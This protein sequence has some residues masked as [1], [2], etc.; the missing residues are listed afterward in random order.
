MMNKMTKCKGDGCSKSAVFDI[1]GG[2]GRYCKTHK[3]VDMVNV[4]SKRCEHEGC[5]SLSTVFDVKGGKG[6]FC[7]THKTANMVSVKGKRCEQEGCDSLSPVYDVKGGKG[8]FCVAHKTADMIDVIHKRCEQEECEKQPCFDIAG[9]KGRFC[10]IHKLADMVNIKSKRCEHEGCDS[11]T[12]SFALEGEKG[13]F[14]AAHKTAEMINVKA[15]RCEHEGCDKQ[16]AFD[17]KGGKP[18]FCA[19]HKAADMVNLVSKRCE[20]A[21]CDKHPNFAAKDGV[22]R[23]CATHR[24]ADMTDV[25]SNRCIH[26]GCDVLKPAF[27]VKGEHGRYCALHKTAD[28]VNVLS[29]RCEHDGCESINRSFD[30]KGGKG[31]FCTIHKTADMV[32]VKVKRCEHEGCDT[33]V[34]YGKPGSKR[35]HCSKHREAGMIR[36]PNAKCVNCKELAIWG[37]HWTPVHCD[38]H[39]TEDDE[40]LAERPCISCGLLYVLDKTNRCELCHPESWATAR[41]VKQTALMDYLD[42]RDLKGAS[43]DTLVDGGVCGKE[44]PDRV[45]DFG[46][47]IVILECDEH[48]HQERACLCEQNRMVN[49]GQTFGGVP[50][51]FIRW[52]PDNYSPKSDRKNPELL[53]KRHKLCGDLIADI[54][55]GKALLPVALVSAIYLYYDDWSSLA[56]ESWSILTK[57]E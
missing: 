26:E 53:A 10:A 36:N 1:K 19:T 21:G 9:G 28:M 33:S 20:H 52:N 29:K 27:N 44:R 3:L 48:Q 41:L 6:R 57:Y 12:P 45:Y 23:F 16:P 4:K 17:V 47:K 14:C 5:E 39:K 51:Y 50:V 43:T 11:I 34:R 25:K 49:I 24:T 35:S 13:R 40:N 18:R 7:S 46:D 56:E 42:A 22:E 54:K 8:R 2:I 38:A 37:T 15:K 30:I 31:R 55:Q 32:D